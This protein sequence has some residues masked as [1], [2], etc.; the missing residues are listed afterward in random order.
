MPGDVCSHDHDCGGEDC[1]SSS[2]HP[3]INH[4]RITAWNAQDDAAAQRVFRP[5]CAPDLVPPTHVAPSPRS[6]RTT[7]PASASVVVVRS[8][9]DRL[10]REGEPLRSDDDPELMVHVPF[11]SDVKVRGV[12]VIGGGSGSAPSR[13]KCWV[14]KAPGEI[15]FANANRKTPTQQW[16]LAE[17]H[18]GTLEYQTDFT[19]FQ[20]VSSL[21]LH[22]PTNLNDDGDT[23]IWFIGLRGEGTINRRDMIVTAVYESR[24]MPQDHKTPDD[25]NVPCQPAV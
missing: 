11:I 18:D 22:F 17:D 12:M 6:H 2:L 14:N 8:R 19:Q 21:T 20:A 3:F 10:S 15:D 24:A 13:L 5:W 7:D 9:E 16:D 4:P 1:G 25:E 23:E